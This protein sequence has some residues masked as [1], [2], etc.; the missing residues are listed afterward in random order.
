MPRFIDFT[1]EDD[2]KILASAPFNRRKMRRAEKKA[3][4]VTTFWIRGQLQKRIPVATGQTRGR[5]TDRVEERGN[6]IL[7]IAGGKSMSSDGFNI[8]RGLEGGTGIY[9]PKKQRIVPVRARVLRFVVSG[10]PVAGTGGNVVF[11]R[12]V[13]GMKPRRPFKKTKKEEGNRA[14]RLFVR[15]LRKE[16]NRT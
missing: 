13:K 7:G 1:L 14:R 16:V 6:E 2:E 11:A 9:G 3:M 10:A 15:Q 5:M 12:S 4:R 8:L